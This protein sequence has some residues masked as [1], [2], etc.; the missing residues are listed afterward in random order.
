MDQCHPTVFTIDDMQYIVRGQATIFIM[1]IF[2]HLPGTIHLLHLGE[3]SA[4]HLLL[5]GLLLLVFGR[6][7]E[8]GGESWLIGSFRGALAP[9]RYSIV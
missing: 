7:S 6:L 9:H 8:E 3:R 4:S 5:R 1:C 2:I